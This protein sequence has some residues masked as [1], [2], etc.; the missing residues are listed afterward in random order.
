MDGQKLNCTRAGPEFVGDPIHRA[1][2]LP[3]G[4]QTYIRALEKSTWSVTNRPLAKKPI[5]YTL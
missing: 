4:Y 5:L 2:Q 3:N 1:L